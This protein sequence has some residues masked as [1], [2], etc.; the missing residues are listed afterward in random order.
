M[1]ILEV[2]SVRLMLRDK[3]LLSGIY[4]KCETGK[5][6]GL[7]ARNGQGKSCLM[8]IIFGNLNC[9]RSIRIDNVQY[10]NAYKNRHMLSFLPQFNF[11]PKSFTLKKIFKDF[12]L[13][14]SIF[15]NQFCE[16]QSK[17]HSSI[18][19]LSGG[20]YRIVEIYVIAKSSSYFVLLDEPFTHLSP[21][22][23][24]KIKELLIEEKVNKGILITDHM[25]REVLDLSDDI[26]ILKDGYT[27]LLKSMDEIIS[28][29]YANI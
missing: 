25:Y 1:H 9:E 4:I 10:Q 26:Y 21:L 12:E 24:E 13:D 19:S 16:F 2:D 8:N 23:I 5:I 29:G 28:L 15:E 3:L 27:H 20:Q 17:Y 7:L 22:Q 14:Y 11:I 18:N 6:T